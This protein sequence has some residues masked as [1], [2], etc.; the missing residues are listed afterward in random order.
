MDVWILVALLVVGLP[1]LAY[2]R[3]QR[4]QRI[5]GYPSTKVKLRVYGTAVV[6]QWSLVAF[7]A[8]ILTRRDLDLNHLFNLKPVAPWAWFAAI[9]LA[10][11]LLWLTRTSLPDVEKTQSKDLPTH[12]QKL[13]RI[14][15]TNGIEIFGFYLLSITAGVCEEILYRGFLF[16]AFDMPAIVLVFLTATIF[17][18]A[19]AYQGVQGMVS[20]GILGIAFAALYYY[21]GSLWPPILLHALIDIGNGYTLGNFAGEMRNKS[22]QHAAEDPPRGPDSPV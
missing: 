16:Y 13:F 2:W 8:W 5:K 12:I 18:F 9:G 7:A 11:L 6:T 1:L 22:D 3:Y 4:L 15:P 14:L 21:G 10:V 20:T 19:H 17:G